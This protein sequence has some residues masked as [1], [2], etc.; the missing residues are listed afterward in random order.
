MKCLIIYSSRSGSTEKVANRIKEVF[1]K[2]GWD[3]D[4]FKIEHGFNVKNPPFD[5]EDYDFLCAGSGTYLRLPTQELLEVMRNYSSKKYGSKRIDPGPKQGLVFVTYAGA[6]LGPKE[7]A[8]NLAILDIE[9]E[10]VGFKTSASLSC[11]GRYK[12]Y[13]TPEW[14]HGDLRDRPNEDDLVG[15]QERVESILKELS[16]ID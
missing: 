16:E 15:I 12:D 10:H 14:F 7:A 11:P 1:D 5:F 3:V 4:I 2:N 6:H 13:D 9:V 8:A